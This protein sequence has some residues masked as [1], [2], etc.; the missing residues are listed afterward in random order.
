[1]RDKEELKRSL[2]LSN[3][4][5]NQLVIRSDGFRQK[6]KTQKPL[7]IRLLESFENRSGE[8]R[9]HH[10][11]PEK[12]LFYN[13]FNYVMHLGNQLGNQLSNHAFRSS[14]ILPVSALVQ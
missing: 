8:T 7:R 6:R 5:G 2:S 4:F 1:M 9:T 13:V 3:E 10:Q 11:S 14:L 12:A